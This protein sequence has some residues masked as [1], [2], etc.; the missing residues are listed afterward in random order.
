MTFH[1]DQQCWLWMSISFL[2]WCHCFPPTLSWHFWSQ[3]LGC[4]SCSIIQTSYWSTW[5]QNS[6]ETSDC[7]SF[8]SWRYRMIHLESSRSSSSCHSRSML[9]CCL[10]IQANCWP[11]RHSCRIKTYHSLSWSLPSGQMSRPCCR[12]SRSFYGEYCSCCQTSLLRH[13][14]R[15]WH[16]QQLASSI[17]WW[18]HR[19]YESRSGYQNYYGYGFCLSLL[20]SQQKLYCFGW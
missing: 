7:G 3:L 5:C 12:L 19:V 18:I 11:L 17:L 6:W 14:N 20:S 10:A 4:C 13:T 1:S 9:R 8:L 2:F 16:S 15:W